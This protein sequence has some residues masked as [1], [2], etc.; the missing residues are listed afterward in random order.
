MRCRTELG[1]LALLDE[2]WKELRECSN[3][4]S[5]YIC[6]VPPRDLTDA[7]FVTLRAWWE[8]HDYTCNPTELIDRIDRMRFEDLN[9]NSQGSG[10]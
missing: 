5:H 4:A 3:A 10:I 6:G 9:L 7:E 2:R 1:F 8:D